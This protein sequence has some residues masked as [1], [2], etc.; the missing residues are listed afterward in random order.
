MYVVWDLNGWVWKERE[1]NKDSKAEFQKNN[2]GGSV[3]IWIR[4]LAVNSFHICLRPKSI[5]WKVYWY[6]IDHYLCPVQ[7]NSGLVGPSLTTPPSH[8]TMITS[9]STDNAGMVGATTMRFVLF[10]TDQRKSG[11]AV[12]WHFT[13]DL[14]WVL[15]G[16]M[17]LHGYRHGVYEA[18]SS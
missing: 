5:L 11:I 12:S 1:K 15:D 3:S 18:T 16:W 8:Q 13:T 10:F 17:T 14:L 4:I 9:Q 6:L 2:N 7:V